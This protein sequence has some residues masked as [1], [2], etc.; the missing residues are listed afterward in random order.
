MLQYN[1]SDA[2]E[3]AWGKPMIRAQRDWSQPKL[4]HHPLAAHVDMRRFLTIKAV[5]EQAIWAWDIGNRWHASHL[6]KPEE[7]KRRDP[8]YT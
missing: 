4:T 6:E 7:H 3:F 8:Q 1:G 2:V 5:E